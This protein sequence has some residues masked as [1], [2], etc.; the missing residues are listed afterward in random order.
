M[1]MRRV[2]LFALVM[3]L[4]ACEPSAPPEHDDLPTLISLPTETDTLPPPEAD[5][6]DAE[7]VDTNATQ[8]ADLGLTQ[9]SSAATVTAIGVDGATLEA[10]A[11]QTGT[12]IAGTEIAALAP[13]FT[14]TTTLPPD[15]T[16]TFTLTPSVT[17]TPSMTITDTPTRTPTETPLP[18]D[19]PTRPSNA[20]GELLRS[21]TPPPPG[22]WIFGTMPGTSVGIVATQPAGNGGT[23]C[24]PPVGGFGSVYTVDPVLAAQ[25]GC[26]SGAPMPFPAAVQTF[27]HGVMIYVGSTPAAIYVL[28]NNGSYSRFND[29]FV[30]GIDPTSGGEMPP[31]GLIEPIRGFGK[32]WR[33]D[34][35]VRNTLGWAI[36]PETGT[37]ATVLLFQTGQMIALPPLGQI[38]VL[39]NVGTYRLLTGSA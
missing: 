14:P 31:P 7:T 3:L 35:T 12:S 24:L 32:V 39:T 13:S 20:I 21:W 36:Q 1:M 23:L 18:T 34:P 15:V 30:D 19:D 17:V 5:T 25:I 28:Y 33:S 6:T 37:T 38:A 2:L 9:T 27:E 11:L 8:L 22:T 29:T 4:A 10:A 26:S 16:A